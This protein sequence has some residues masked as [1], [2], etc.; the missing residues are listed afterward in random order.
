MCPY[1]K[2]L[3]DLE[4]GDISTI[5]NNNG[6]IVEVVYPFEKHNQV[7]NLAGPTKMFGLKTNISI[8]GNK[9]EPR[10]HEL[11]SE[12]PRGR[13]MKPSRQAS[14]PTKKDD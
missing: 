11:Q 6:P 9:Q 7:T 10:M 12:R 1:L 2:D 4:V 5:K 8:V 14:G 13:Q 3:E